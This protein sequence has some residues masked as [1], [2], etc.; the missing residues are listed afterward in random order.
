MNHASQ[1]LFPADISI[2]YFHRLQRYS[3]LYRI[4]LA[5]PYSTKLSYKQ[6]YRINLKL[7]NELDLSLI[8]EQKKNCWLEVGCHLLVEKNKKIVPC[9]DSSIVCRPLKHDEWDSTTASDIAGFQNDAVGD[10]E[11][12]VSL[13]DESYVSPS[14]ENAKHYIQIYPKA[15]KRPSI[16]AFQLMIGPI[17]ITESLMHYVTPPPNHT[18]ENKWKE[19]NTSSAIFHGYR[20]QDSSYLIIREDWDL[21]TPGKMWD[22]ALVL[23]QMM[24]DKI[25]QDP[26]YFQGNRLID[27]SAG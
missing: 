26:D 13:H 11:F 19:P 17:S 18:L 3:A 15:Q 14:T 21:G 24:T 22:S 1:A 20:L 4:L 9:T 23:S 8:E 5:A 7:V 6:W 10:F 16:M 12:M 27:L 2:D 25:S